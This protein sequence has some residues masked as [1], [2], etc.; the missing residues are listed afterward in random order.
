MKC[1]RKICYLIYPFK[2]ISKVSVGNSL[3]NAQQQKE[4]T[5]EQIILGETKYKLKTLL[6]MQPAELP[7]RTYSP[8][9]EEN[10]EGGQS[11]D[12]IEDD[13][14]DMPY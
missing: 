14:K 9:E 12:E 11:S 6:K 8:E 10:D 5:K 7:G 3:S 4:I 1:S 13:N 2:F